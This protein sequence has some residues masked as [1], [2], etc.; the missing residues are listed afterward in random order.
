MNRPLSRR[1]LLSSLAA[2]PAVAFIA[3][4]SDSEEEA[5]AAD[6]KP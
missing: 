6:A 5:K 2:I 1:N 3:A 4:C